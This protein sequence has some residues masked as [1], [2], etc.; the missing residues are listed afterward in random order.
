MRICPKCGDYY[1]DG[2]LAFCLADGAP[3]V[4]VD[5][6]SQNWSEGA[7]VIAEKAKALSKQKRR[8]KWRRVALGTMMIL[9][10][11]AFLLAAA[12]NRFYLEPPPP[13]PATPTP[14]PSPTPTPALFKIN[15]QVTDQ[16]KPL[17][18]VRIMLSGTQPGS[19]TT[20]ANGD[21]TFIDLPAGGIYT[22]SPQPSG[23]MTFKPPNHP[24]NKLTEDVS[25][26]FVLVVYKI[27]GR[28]MDAD[29][30]LPEVSITL[31][32]GVKTISMTTDKNGKYA[33]SG[34][35]AGGKYTITPLKGQMVFNPSRPIDKL[36]KD[37]TVD[38]KLVVYKIS[39]RVM[40]ADKPLSEVS[41]RLFDGTKTVPAT[42][43][44]DGKYAFSGLPAGARYTI[45]PTKGQMIFDPPGYSFDKL[46]KNESVNFGRRQTD[47]YKIT[48]HVTEAIPGTPAVGREG[49]EVV[50][51][52][53][54]NPRSER[55]DEKGGYTFTDVPA[56]GSYSVSVDRKDL[57]RDSYHF[58]RLGKDE[59]ADFVIDKSRPTPTPTRR[60]IG[61]VTA[62]TPART[63]KAPV[64]AEAN[65]HR[66]RRRVAMLMSGVT[67]SA[68]TAL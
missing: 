51:K 5:P 12:Q 57:R 43:G 21:Y 8:L 2:S 41:L 64:R 17:S 46:T 58:D 47:V 42:T 18:G 7:R 35:A 37:E 54:A 63:A 44:K 13:P 56:G 49:V 55:T 33:F 66:D 34:L 40:D 59:T 45:T 15:G 53:G 60:K 4:G 26:D 32:D 3:L 16:D 61:R 68:K 6:G 9:T 52:G 19:T 30:P 29:T 65:I 25:V 38:F 1:A 20:D 27:S 11:V 36:T 28:V 39:G 24:I 22:I 10:V 62:P 31:F 14:T 67:F 48:G 23:T 50:L